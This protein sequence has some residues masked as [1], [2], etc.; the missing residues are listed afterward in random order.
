MFKKIR[1]HVYSIDFLIYYLLI[2]YNIHFIRNTS[3]AQL[4][5]K[6]PSS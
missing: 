4:K 1:N 5:L 6:E 2:T 3:A